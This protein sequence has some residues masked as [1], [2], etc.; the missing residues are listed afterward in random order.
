MTFAHFALSER[1]KAANCSGGVA[2]DFGAVSTPVFSRRAV[3]GLDDF[4]VED[5]QDRLRG[6]G[7]REE[8]RSTRCLDAR[9]PA[10]AVVGTS[11]RSRERDGPATASC[12]QFPD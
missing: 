3:V 6:S 4:A 7:G 5:L 2:D 12:A 10:S 1:T 11:G 8:G 9:E